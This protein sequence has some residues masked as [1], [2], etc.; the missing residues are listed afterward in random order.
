MR[1]RAWL[2]GSLMVAG[3]YL[4]AV[5]PATTYKVDSE[6]TSVTFTVR[7]LFTKVMG[8]FDK[9]DGK[10]VYDPA[11]P[12]ATKVEGSIDVA[13]INTNVAKRDEHLRSKDFFYVE[14]FPKITFASTGVADGAPGKTS[15]KL[16]G[17]LSIRGVEKPV[18][19]DVS[20]LGDGMDP[21][22]N[23]RA[24][25]S[26]QVTINRKD[27]GLTWNEKLETG[28]VLVG[29]EVT[30]QIEAEGTVAE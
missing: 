14:K 16:T 20:F 7:H 13:S 6:H 11:K 17:T 23:R 25:F 30:I 28:G 19:L 8:R 26:G 24:G 15:G 1:N 3:L 5:A 2:V 4:P 12:Q 9:F 21:W 18:T 22:G 27:F 10:I 29:D